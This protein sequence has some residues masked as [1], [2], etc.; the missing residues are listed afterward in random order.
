MKPVEGQIDDDDEEAC[1]V[2]G[3]RLNDRENYE[4]CK[5][6]ASNKLD[7]FFHY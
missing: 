7:G 1:Y 2:V 5:L 3:N 6:V 4:R